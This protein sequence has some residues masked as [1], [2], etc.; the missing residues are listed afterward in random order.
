MAGYDAVFARYYDSLTTDIDY[1]RRG[2]Y[3]RNLAKEFG[4]KFQLVLDLACGTGSL[5]VELARLGAEVIGVDGSQ[6]MLSCAM[7]KSAGVNPAIL[8]LCQ[9]MEELDLY[10]TVDTTICALDSLNHLPG[11]EA[12]AKVLHRVWLFTEPG[13]LFLFDMNTPYKH[14]HQL[15]GTTYVR[16]T[17]EVYCVWQNTLNPVDKSVGIDLDFFVKGEKNH[18]NR[19]SESFREYVYTAEE[20]TELLAQEG[21]RLLDLRGDYTKT[22]PGPEE[23]RVVYIARRM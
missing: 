1:R 18:Y 12:L 8:Y 16:E 23:A 20:M 19:Y 3:L 17:K 14:T 11:K 7:N 5:S 2:E 6:E 10:G 9:D 22:A 21:F 13:G 15:N 4:G